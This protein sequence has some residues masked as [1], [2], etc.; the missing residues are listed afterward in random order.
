MQGI[1]EKKFANALALVASIDCESPEQRC[2][3]QRVAR[4]FL[5]HVRRQF[6][7]IDAVARER[8]AAKDRGIVALRRQDE[9]HVTNAAKI[10]SCLFLQVPVYPD[11]AT[12]PP[13]PLLPA[14]KS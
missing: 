10:L 2:R 4:E 3:N 8:L 1:H 14:C 12:R 7:D 9:G 11:I 5:H 6:A 13:P